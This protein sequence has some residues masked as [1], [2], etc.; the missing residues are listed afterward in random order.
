M[1]KWILSL[2]VLALSFTSQSQSWDLTGNAGTNPAVNFVGTRDNQPLRF[3]IN[4]KY[5][6]EIDSV[7]GRTF[8]GFEAGKIINSRSAAYNVAIGFRALT[9]NY[10]GFQNTAIG[11]YSLYSNT[12]GSYNVASGYG[13]LYLNSNG[14]SNTA[15]GY[16]SLTQNTSG[17]DNCAYGRDAV[18]TNTTGGYNTAIGSSALHQTI[19]SY[20][21]TCV[22]YNAGNSYNMGWNNTLIGANCDVSFADQYNS[23]ALGESAIC[24][25]NSTARIG[26]SATWSIGGFA[27]WSNF[28]DGR[29][30][31]DIK[32][33]VKGID[34]IMKL[35]P[36]TYRL[37]ITGVSKQLKENRG[38]EWAPQMK[39]AIAEKEK[40]IFSGFVAQD[41]EQAAKETGYDFSGV[42]K[43][44]NE[45]NFYGL[46][47]ADFVVP[48][49]KAMQEQ[50]Q[51]INELK[52]LN[53]DLQKR[54]AE[55][56]KKSGTD[57]LTTKR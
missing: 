30:K 31:K 23:V 25:D 13:A 35:R 14:G 38:E 26:N 53:T 57:D 28:S 9:S 20:Y 6:G 24:P 49:V 7:F 55:L 42:D 54:V 1:K 27:G 17:S 36:V 39:T 21:N 37:D 8:L 52:K 11:T 3:R 18:R 19:S 46:R 10:A 32:E 34:F 51:M 4:N 29:Y 22:G 40:M 5:A 56:E 41:V 44:K 45:N 43:P 48:L 15:M 2:A 12:T 47:Y 33:N 50:Q 16:G